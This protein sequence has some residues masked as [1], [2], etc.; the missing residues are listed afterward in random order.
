MQGFLHADCVGDELKLLKNFGLVAQDVAFH[1]VVD[2]QLGQVALEQAVVLGYWNI[3]G[4]Q[5]LCSLRE[6]SLFSDAG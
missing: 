3:C 6:R 2:Q 5:F 4:C 1:R